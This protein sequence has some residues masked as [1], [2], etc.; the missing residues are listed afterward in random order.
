MCD[1]KNAHINCKYNYHARYHL[2]LMLIDV[3]KQFFCFTRNLNGIIEMQ[4]AVIT[5][6]MAFNYG[7]LSPVF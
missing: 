2:T 1:A 7:A 6:L 3:G 5:L 4:S